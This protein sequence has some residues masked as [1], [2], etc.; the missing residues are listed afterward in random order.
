MRCVAGWS[1]VGVWTYE[2]LCY[3]AFGRLGYVLVCSFMIVFAFGA[4]L[5]YHLI[6]GDT[7]PQVKLQAGWRRLV[8]GGGVAV[9]AGG[10]GAV[11]IES[12]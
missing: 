7:I 10:A 6:I 11:S 9:R 8:L 12:L 4:L 1:Q 3:V 2:E 5:A